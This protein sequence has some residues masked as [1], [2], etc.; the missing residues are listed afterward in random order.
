MEVAIDSF[1]GALEGFEFF[2][3]SPLS[4]LNSYEEDDLLRRFA[5][6]ISISCAF[7][8][9]SWKVLGLLIYKT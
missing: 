6:V 2:L 4:F 9:S 5:I 1:A 8:V 7:V 3:I